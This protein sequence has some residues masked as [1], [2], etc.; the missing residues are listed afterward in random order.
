LEYGIPTYETDGPIAPPERQRVEGGQGDSAG[1]VGVAVVVGI[2]SVLGEDIRVLYPLIVFQ[3]ITL[4][5]HYVPEAAV[6]DSRFKDL[7]DLPPLVS[8][9]LEDGW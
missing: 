2:N 6:L 7:I 4:L 5:A 9:C 1:S 8:V 3:T